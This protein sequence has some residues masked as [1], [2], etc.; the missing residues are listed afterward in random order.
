PLDAAGVA[1]TF[2]RLP[3]PATL[4]RIRRR[5]RDGCPRAPGPGTARLSTSRLPAG[6]SRGS[7]AGG[8]QTATGEGAQ[9]RGVGRSAQSRAPA[10]AQGLQTAARLVG[11]ALAAIITAPRP[12][13]SRINPLL[14]INANP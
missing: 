14:P 1:A 11:A 4:R 2:R 12:A 3:P 7:A 13:F 5:L 6:R 10:G 9:G 8:G